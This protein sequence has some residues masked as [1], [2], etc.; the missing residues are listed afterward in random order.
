MRRGL[1]PPVLIMIV[2]ICGSTSSRAAAVPTDGFKSTGADREAIETL[3]ASYTKAVTSKNEALFESL[4]LDKGIPFSGVQSAR[5][6]GGADIGTRNYESFRK[7]VFHGPP[8]TQTFQDIHILQDGPLAEV[9]LVFVNKAPN[10]NSWG[11]KTLQLLK[12][13]GL[14]KIASEFYTGH[15][16]AKS[17]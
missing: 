4:L 16:L 5:Q 7:G 15:A 8:F 2:A 12:A 3:L 6:P 17:S 10:G 1:V 14:W 13:A 9:S 11:W